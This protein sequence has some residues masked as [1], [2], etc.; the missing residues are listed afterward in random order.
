MKKPTNPAIESK[1]AVVISARGKIL[2]RLATE[3]ATILRGKDSVHFESHLLSGRPVVVTHAKEIVTTGNKLEQKVYY[4]HSGY[5]G[6]LKEE[7]LG[8]LLQR[9]PEDVIRHAVKGMLPKNR[10][11]KHWLASLEIRPE[12]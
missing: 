5:I 9:K 6:N 3:V 4:R 12:A 7:T 11:Q 2:G 10:L 1:T 8:K